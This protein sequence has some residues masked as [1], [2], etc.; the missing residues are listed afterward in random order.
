MRRFK[1]LSMLTLVLVVILLT[2]TAAYA[3]AAYHGNWAEQ[4]Y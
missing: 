1:L 2:A 3:Y 4:P